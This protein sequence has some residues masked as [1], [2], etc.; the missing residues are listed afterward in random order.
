ML[1]DGASTTL[2]LAVDCLSVNADTE[3]DIETSRTVRE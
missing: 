1:A 3:I 2:N